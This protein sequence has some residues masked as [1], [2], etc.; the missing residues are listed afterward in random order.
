M[1][2]GSRVLCPASRQARLHALLMLALLMLARNLLHRPPSSCLPMHYRSSRKGT[3]FPPKDKIFSAFTA[4]PFDKVRVVVLG[5]DPYH[6]PG[7]AHGLAFSVEKGIAIPPSLRNMIKEA[8]QDVGIT[9]PG[10]GNLQ[11]WYVG[12][13]TRVG[14]Q[15]STCGPVVGQSVVGW[16]HRDAL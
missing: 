1:V 11:H 7:Q 2:R 15:L 16:P 9:K 10:H 4:C 3:V 12:A 5:Q 14:S 13:A 8:V 6:G